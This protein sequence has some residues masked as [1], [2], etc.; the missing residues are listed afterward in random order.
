[1]KALIYKDFLALLKYCRFHLVLCGI[2]L[3][4]SAFAGEMEFMRIYVLVF[5]GLMPVSLIAY[6]E[7][8]RWDRMALTMPLSRRMIVTEKYL[9]GLLMQGTAAILAGVS[10]LVQ[11]AL[12][13]VVDWPSLFGELLMML[14]MAIAIPLLQLPVI[15]KVGAERGRMAQTLVLCGAMACI[16]SGAVVLSKLEAVLEI[17]TI[18]VVLAGAAAVLLYPASW[19]LSVYWYGKREF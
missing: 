7:S 2:F 14:V 4:A 17:D 15:F 11:V 1:M 13:G 12:A 19:A 9:M 5:T 10:M 16:V 8:E 3:T 18:M 6:E